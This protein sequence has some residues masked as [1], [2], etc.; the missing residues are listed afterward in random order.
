[1]DTDLRR[2][3]D[4]T[5]GGD[6]ARQLDR[7]RADLAAWLDEDDAPHGLR[8]PGLPARAARLVLGQAV[9]RHPWAL[10][11]GA[12]AAGA[13]LAATRP[14]HRLLRPGLLLAV[15]SPLVSDLAGRWL[16]RALAAADP[17]TP[18]APEQRR[19]E[20]PEAKAAWPPSPHKP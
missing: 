7:S 10:M 18:P 12:A 14:W 3:R 6:A 11:A 1:M 16:Q 17:Q 19:R 20:R 4:D 8:P 5:C 9:R 13:V 15:A 2:A